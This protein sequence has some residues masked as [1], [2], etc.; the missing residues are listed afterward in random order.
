MHCDKI[1]HLDKYFIKSKLN[2]GSHYCW[3]QKYCW[4]QWTFDWDVELWDVIC[5][6]WMSVWVWSSLPGPGLCRGGWW[7]VSREAGAGDCC[8]SSEESSPQA[9][10][11]PEAEKSVTIKHWLSLSSLSSATLSCCSWEE[12]LRSGIILLC[13]MFEGRLSSWVPAPAPAPTT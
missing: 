8:H 7:L 1:W 4:S 2:D 9:E 11:G 6:C 10:T 13:W 12:L 3:V 5:L